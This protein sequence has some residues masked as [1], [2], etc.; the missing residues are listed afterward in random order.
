MTY[1]LKGSIS[2]LESNLFLFFQQKEV[3]CDA[4]CA[5]HNYIM[6]YGLDD[7]LSRNVELGPIDNDVRKMMVP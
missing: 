6:K 5:V 3:Y 2:Y 1:K 7:W 4:T